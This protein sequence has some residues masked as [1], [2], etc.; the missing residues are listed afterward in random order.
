MAAARRRLP[1][2]RPL[3]ALFPLLLCAMPPSC[4]AGQALDR[5]FAES[6]RCADPECSMLMCRGK[7][8]KN[9]KGPDC[10]FVDFKEGESVYVYYKL[11]GR[12][13][14]LWAASVGS[15]FGYFPKDLL[16]INHIYTHDEIELPTDETD[17]VCFDGGKD[18]F[19]NYNAEELLKL[20]E[21]MVASD[22][23]AELEN[24]EE[25]EGAEPTKSINSEMYDF[26]VGL[27]EDGEDHAKMGEQDRFLFENNENVERALDSKS[28]DLVVNSDLDNPQ[29]DQ[30]AHQPSEEMLQEMLKMPKHENAKNSSVSQDKAKQS[31]NG[32][33]DDGAYTLLNQ[34]M[35]EDLKTTFGSTADALV[36]DDETTS[37][38]TSLDADFREDLD[39]DSSD[40]EKLEEPKEQ[41]E[42]IH[43]LS[44]TEKERKSSDDPEAEELPPDGVFESEISDNDDSAGEAAAKFILEGKD[45]SGLLTHLGDNF[46]AIVSGGEKTIDEAVAAKFDLEEEEDDDDEDDNVAVINKKE[47]T[48]DVFS[49][50]DSSSEDHPFTLEH[51]LITKKAHSVDVGDHK[52]KKYKTQDNEEGHA[53]TEVEPTT[54]QQLQSAPPHNFGAFSNY[55]GGRQPEASMGTKEKNVIP[56]LGDIRDDPEGLSIHKIIKDKESGQQK[57]EE[58]S[59]ENDTKHKTLWEKLGKKDEEGKQPMNIVPDLLEELTNESESDLDDSDLLE[60]K[61]KQDE[62]DLELRKMLSNKKQSNDSA[63]ENNPTERDAEVPIA[64][65]EQETVTQDLEDEEEEKEDHLTSSKKKLE[66]K[67]IIEN[68][69]RATEHRNLT[70][71]NIIHNEAE[72]VDKVAGIDTGGV[73]SSTEQLKPVE[74]DAEEDTFL[75]ELEQE[76]LQDENA[77]SAKL[78]KERPADEQSFRLDA[79][80]LLLQ[81]P[82]GAISR[83]ANP[84]DEMGEA[85]TLEQA[86]KDGMED[87]NEEHEGVQIN[88]DSQL[89]EGKEIKEEKQEVEPTTLSQVENS[90]LQEKNQIQDIHDE[91][92]SSK[93]DI[94]ELESKDDFNQTQEHLS[95]D[96]SQKVLKDVQISTEQQHSSDPL[97]TT[98]VSENTN[99][100]P[101]YSEAVRQLFIM[102]E[103]LDEKRIARIQ[104]YLGQQ[105]I[106]R[107]ESLFHDME[108]ELIFAQKQ[109][110]NHADTEKALDQI[111]ESSESNILDVL[112]KVLDSREVENKEEVIKEMDWFDEEAALLDDIQELMYS[113]RQKYSPVSESAPLAFLLESGMDSNEPITANAKETEHDGH[114]VESPAENTDQKLPQ[115]VEPVATKSTKE[116]TLHLDQPKEDRNILAETGT[117][118][119]PEIKDVLD[120]DKR[121]PNVDATFGSVDSGMERDFVAGIINAKEDVMEEDSKPSEADSA[122]PHTLTALGGAVL[123]AKENIQPF[124][125]ILVSTLP[126]DMRPGPDFHGL[127]WESI[128]ITAFVGIATLAIFFWRTCLSVKSRMYQV[129]EK[130]LV[131]K[132]KTLLKEKTEILEKMSEYDQKIKEA[133]ESVKEAQKQNTNLSDMTTGLK[134]TVRGLKETNHLLDDR[135]KNL[136]TMLEIEREHNAKKQEQLIEAQK[137]LEKLQEIITL[138]SVELSE[139]QIALNETKLS[140]EKVKSDL[141]H[142]QEENVRLKKSKEQLLKE[143]EGWSERHS[144]LSEQIKLYQKSQKDIEEALAYK[145]NEIEVLTNCIMQLK[146][147]DAE[148]ESEGKRDDGNDLANGELSD[149]RNEKMKNQIKQM[150]DVSRVKTTLSIIEEERDLLRSKLNDEVAARHELEEQIKKLEHDSYSLQT[151]KSQLESECKTL[152]Q[153]VEILNEL[154]QQKEM[155]LQKKLTLEEYERQEKEQK[156]SAA[157]EKAIL[158]VEEVKVYK[159]RIQEMEEELQKTERS[160]K[161]QIA[162]HEKKAH[163]N[164]L[165]ARSAERALVE[166][167]RENANLRHKLME[168]DQKIAALQRPLIVKPTAG[169][170]DHQVP[171]RRGPLS[172]DGSFGPSPVSGGAPSPPLMMEP[173]GRPLSAN[174][175]EVSRVAAMVD[176]PP[177]PRRHSELSG[178]MSAPDLGP[179]VASLINC[180]PR[181]SSPSSTVLDGMQNPPKEHEAPCVSTVPPSSAEATAVSIGSKG[182]PPFPGAP[183]MTAPATGP[184]PP[185]VRFGPPPRPP[186]GPLPLPLARGAPPPPVLRDYPP[187]PPFGMRDFPSGPLPPPEQRGYLRGPPPFRPPHVREYP[188]GPPR[189]PSE[190]LRDYPPPSVRDLPPSGSENYQGGPSCPPSPASSRDSAH[191]PEQKP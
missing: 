76:L 84:V 114:V 130:Q 10:R 3:F 158:A 141:H 98:D 33:K 137:S 172:R 146:Q 174:P 104:K 87:F 181:T 56:P 20:S 162:S 49:N 19:D 100:E 53:K 70:Q 68:P 126:E 55:G 144:E 99:E 96:F 85:I 45:G 156:L 24:E 54:E 77:V 86:E 120:S 61:T 183:I 37:L 25:I 182:P 13:N 160:Y 169:R 112:N 47:Y 119:E 82:N 139:V 163:D 8:M 12:S 67:L 64:Q 48:E 175:R 90:L 92:N 131:E 52:E 65:S 177:F 145:E 129:T 118:D 46:F 187:G 157:D 133:K 14:E 185:P 5:R 125:E 62:E 164:W 21:V 40:T 1:L 16:E 167:K 69:R 102:K 171:P 39:I 93:I 36:S 184:L 15:E 97:G 143:A 74:L 6:K 173:L 2:V 60:D 149:T 188:P 142:M 147:L 89:S 27:E 170:P 101:Q 23:E 176:G 105:H 9:F 124:T 59:L 150:M 71:Q 153:K 26:E 107:I 28:E 17:F 34:E 178:R 51:V 103:F 57:N 83:A 32:D 78:S 42:E 18:D 140:E 35:S 79:E 116:E 41:S 159:Q 58:D 122:V 113:L 148:S 88:G 95:K 44:F 117:L 127:P 80:S 94:S 63:M 109:N 154:Y 75:E 191:H 29:G 31:D 152:Q 7:A 106:F 151:A 136:H 168:M 165:I 11:T 179:A 66:K 121:L 161:N 180:G 108:L 186:Y 189:L 22:A 4:Q 111:L 135:V 132:I 115:D 166:E 155:A 134:D 72:N 91:I 138:H 110:D 123:L 128:I 73:K 30:S 190:G 38:V 43:L 81:M 50:L